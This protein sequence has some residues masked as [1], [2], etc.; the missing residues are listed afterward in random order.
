M[1]EVNFVT[2]FGSRQEQTNLNKLILITQPICVLC[3]Y[4][5]FEMIISRGLVRKPAALRHLA[6]LD[7]TVLPVISAAN[8]RNGRTR[9]YPFYRSRPHKTR[10]RGQRT[11]ATRFPISKAHQKTCQLLKMRTTEL[12]YNALRHT[13]TSVITDRNV[14]FHAI[15]YR[16]EWY[17]S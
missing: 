5:G 1:S 16:I 14:Q 9:R 8:R 15:R 4:F 7:T 12:H 2:Q 13:V 10:S 11:D 17:W 6:G 3:T